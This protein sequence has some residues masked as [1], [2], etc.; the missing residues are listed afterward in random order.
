MFDSWLRFYGWTLKGT[1]RFKGTTMVVSALL[2][3]GTVYLYRIV[4]TGFIPSVD[5]G[6]LSGQIEAMQGIGF[7]AMVAHQKEVMAILA[8]DDPNVASFTSN[9]GGV[10][11]AA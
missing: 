7:D 1:I 8:K 6:Q 2:L 3:V 9:V 5:T 11:A 10:A 4:P